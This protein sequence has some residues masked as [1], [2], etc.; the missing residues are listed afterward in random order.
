MV[1]TTCRK[2]KWALDR[3][4]L[5]TVVTKMQEKDVKQKP[6]DGC[7]MIGLYIEGADWDVERVCLKRQ[8]PKELI[9]EMP[10]IQIV[11]V[12]ANKLKLKDNINI[13]VYVT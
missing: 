9:K 7:Y 2:K 4:T 6:E 13:P 3:S 5:Y 10:V 1:Q 8:N 11:P 12:E